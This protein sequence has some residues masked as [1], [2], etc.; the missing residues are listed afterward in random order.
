MKKT[1]WVGILLL[2]LV[3]SACGSAGTPSAIPTVNLDN[4]NSPT[5]DNSSSDGNSVSASAVIVPVNDAQLSFA[6]VGKVTAVNVKVGDQ[7]KTG[8]ILVTLDT[9]ILEAKV[10]EAEANLEAAQAQVRFLKRNKT[11]E[12]HLEVA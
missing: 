11:D 4:G 12:V 9:A 2:A 1:L 10:R 3:L 6:S 8:D 7:V 5:T